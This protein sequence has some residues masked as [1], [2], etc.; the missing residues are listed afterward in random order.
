MSSLIEAKIE[1][2]FEKHLPL[3]FI[4]YDVLTQIKE[5]ILSK[6]HP[7]RKEILIFSYIIG[8]DS[9]ESDELLKLFGYPLLYAKK[10]E[11]VIWKYALDNRA[12]SASIIDE[13]FLQNVDESSVE[14]R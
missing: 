12:D 10:R 4:D 1:A 8:A 5:S 11:D 3:A 2:L 7:G 9:K 6:K 14:T 13:I